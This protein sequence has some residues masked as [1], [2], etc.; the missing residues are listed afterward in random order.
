[1]PAQARLELLETAATLLLMGGLL[2]SLTAAESWFWL[3]D[4]GF[5]LLTTSY[6]VKGVCRLRARRSTTS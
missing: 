3:A 1:M 6:A 4:T 2:L 5:A